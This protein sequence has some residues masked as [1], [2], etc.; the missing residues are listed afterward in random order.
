MTTTRIRK[1]ACKVL[2]EASRIVRPMELLFARSEEVGGMAARPIF[3]VGAPRC[4]STLLFQAL[5]HA[6]EFCHFTNFTAHFYHSPRVGFRLQRILRSRTKHEESFRSRHGVTPG[7]WGPHECGKFWRRWFPADRD[8]VGEDEFDESHH[9]RLR[10]EIAA[11]GGIEQKPTLF[12]NL[13]C[14]QRLQILTRLFP[15]SVYIFCRRDPFYN[16]QSILLGRREVHGAESKWWSVRPSTYPDLRRLGIF[17]QVARQVADIERQI[18]EDLADLDPMR[19]YR[20]QYE[21]LCGKPVDEVGAIGEWLWRNRIE[22]R[23]RQ[24]P[25]P[26]FRCGNIDRL[27]ETEAGE[28]RRATG[29]FVN[30]KV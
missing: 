26:V 21:N 17:E 23:P 28:L 18:E 25:P 7:L 8:F 20:L 4:G 15:E 1:G 27:S 9:G 14:G 10:K 24:S 13:N 29:T 3:I 30:S 6:Y 12:K 2:A 16:A 11:I 5:T 22:V 19:S